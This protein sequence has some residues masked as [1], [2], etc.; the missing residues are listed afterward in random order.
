MIPARP[1]PVAQ[2]GDGC[3]GLETGATGGPRSRG[4]TL[5]EVLLAVT[6]MASLMGLVASMIGQAREWTEVS[7]VDRVLMRVQRVGEAMRSQW[8]DRR[9]SMALDERGRRVITTPTEL[10]YLTA[11]P[12]LFPE[13]PLV[14][15]TYRIEPESTRGTMRGLTWRLVYEEVRVSGMDEL[16]D[17]YALDITGQALR[18]STVLLAGCTELR[19]ERFGRGERVDESGSV[20]EEEEEDD[21]G[22]SPDGSAASGGQASERGARRDRLEDPDELEEEQ[23]YLWREFTDG[24]E[25]FVPAVRLVGDYE[26]ERFGWVFVIKAL[27]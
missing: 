10:R 19:W 24:Y 12:L 7:E 8:T 26:G 13:W 21:K 4:M 9:S 27:R 14:A 11:T 25:G 18:D 2:C 16:P 6:I 3:I 5:L 17:Q 15:A 23:R 1:N 20:P 22:A